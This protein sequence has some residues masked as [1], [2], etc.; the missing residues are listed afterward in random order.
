MGRMKNSLPYVI[1]CSPRLNS[2]NKYLV[3]CF[4]GGNKLLSLKPRDPSKFNAE[5]EAL[6]VIKIKTLSIK[7]PEIDCP[8]KLSFSSNGI[9]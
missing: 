3:A 6:V 2:C 4:C 5:I 1:I 8:L 9:L 7:P